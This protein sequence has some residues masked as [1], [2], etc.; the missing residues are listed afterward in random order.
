MQTIKLNLTLEEVNLVLESLGHMP[1]VRVFQL[2]SKLQQQAMPQLQENQA[3]FEHA[4]QL[5]NEESQKEDAYV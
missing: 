5:I 4:S 2:I 3:A 1:Y